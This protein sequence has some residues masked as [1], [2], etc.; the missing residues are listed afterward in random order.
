MAQQKIIN[1]F[2]TLIGWNNMSFPL[3]GRNVE[4]IAKVSYTD[5]QEMNNEYGQGHM[6]IG[7]SVGN[8]EAQ[9]GVDLYKEEVIAIQKSLPKGKRMQ[10]AAPFD[11][12]IVYEFNGEIYKD[13]IRNC[14]FK[15]NGAEVS[16]GDGKI[17][18]SYDLLCSHI[19]YNV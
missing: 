15:N 11:F 13:V 7:Q 3:F 6:P 8:Y 4:G 17:V 9:A 5:N 2:G 19:D 16:Q 18:T 12:P 1:K 14:R 10:D